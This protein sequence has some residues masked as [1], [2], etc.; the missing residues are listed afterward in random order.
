MNII[1]LR[2]PSC[3][4]RRVAVAEHVLVD[5]GEVTVVCPACNAQCKV[6]LTIDV[7]DELVEKKKRKKE[8]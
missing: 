7:V 8:D 6:K 4:H 3:Q 1:Y 2:C 5:S